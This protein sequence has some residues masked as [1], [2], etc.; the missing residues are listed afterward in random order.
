MAGVV[1]AAA[2]HTRMKVEAFM[3]MMALRFAPSHQRYLRTHRVKRARLNAELLLR[4]AFLYVELMLRVP[5]R[6]LSKEYRRRVGR[7][8]R[9]W[10]P[11]LL[12]SFL[13]KCVMHYHYFTMATRMVR[14]E[15]AVVTSY[16]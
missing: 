9:Q 1:R 5:D 7:I 11:A 12:L 15:S 6:M 2:R 13:L 3:G 4:S 10:Q 8:A 14:Q 16:Q